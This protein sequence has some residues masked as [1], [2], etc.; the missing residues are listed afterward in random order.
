[1]CQWSDES[2]VGDRLPHNKVETCDRPPC[3]LRVTNLGL[4][5]N[6]CCNYVN[7]ILLV[8]KK[9][10]NKD[11]HGY[12]LIFVGS[13]RIERDS[14]SGVARSYCHA[15][16]PA[17]GSRS[18]GGQASTNTGPLSE[19]VVACS[20]CDTGVCGFFARRPRFCG[21]SFGALPLGVRPSNSITTSPVSTSNT[22]AKYA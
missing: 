14:T 16:P 4:Y 8:N 5:I 17:V 9:V 11:F 19:C 10:L 3:M 7:S 20:G 21:G 13:S 22:H 18:T 1:M 2:A 12:V 15:T 6:L